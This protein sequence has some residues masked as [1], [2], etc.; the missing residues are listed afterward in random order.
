MTEP[1]TLT[2]DQI[3]DMAARI[4]VRV[5]GFAVDTAPP[6]LLGYAASLKA[7]VLACLQATPDIGRAPPPAI[8]AA[9]ANLARSRLIP[10]AA[11]DKTATAYLYLQ[12]RALV[13]KP[14]PTGRLR[15]AAAAGADVVTLAVGKA[16]KVSLGDDGDVVDVAVDPDKRPTAWADLRGV[17][18]S[19]TSQDTG[20][21]RRVW[22]SAGEIDVRKR[23]SSSGDKG[24]WASDPVG[25]ARSKAVS[26]AVD[27]GDIP[28][29]PVRF[30]FGPAGAPAPQLATA[31]R[32]LPAPAEPA[33]EPQPE[34]PTPAAPTAAPE[35]AGAPQ[36]APEAPAEPTP[37]PTPT[38]AAA[39]AQEATQAPQDAPAEAAA[40]AAPE[41]TWADVEAAICARVR[42]I[43]TSANPDD[44]GAAAYGAVR[45]AQ[46]SAQA[47]GGMLTPRAAMAP[48]SLDKLV[49]M[50]AIR[51][52]A[53]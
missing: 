9:L 8:F 12:N 18:V 46:A 42:A 31:P 19:I 35:A 17:V 47:K 43:R 24:P 27:R 45:E 37:E 40:E 33:P 22:V 25:M 50:A 26:I 41:P 13:G 29:A 32:A 4:A 48:K 44:V 28:Q 23:K 38:D 10:G 15:M 3:G 6:A 51:L 7:A 52:D 16:D 49:A 34:A 2:H 5:H 1:T 21:V 11:G 53:M 20:A 36:A 39:Q 14:N 30:A